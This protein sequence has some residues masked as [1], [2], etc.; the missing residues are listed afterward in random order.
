MDKNW[1]FLT[2]DIVCV[3]RLRH[4]LGCEEAI[5]RSLVN[6]GIHDP[7]HAQA[8]IHTSLN[9]LKP[10]FCLKDMDKAVERTARA[11]H[12]NESIL[13]FG[14][15]DADGITATTILCGFLRECGAHVSS[16]LPHR[17]NEGY[18]LKPRHIVHFKDNMRPD[19]LITV[20]CGTSSHDAVKEATAAGIDV[21]I[22]DHHDAESSPPPA[23]AV[24]NPKQPGCTSGL[25]H[26][27]GVGVAFYFIMALRKYLRDHH[28]FKNR[29]EPNLKQMCDLVAIGT[30]A[31]MVPLVDENR[32]FIHTGVHVLKTAT[33]HGLK[34]LMHMAQ[35]TQ[36][37]LTAEDIAFKIA[38]RINSAGRI[39]HAQIA[40]D[41]LN[42]SN[43]GRCL[44]LAQHLE[45]LNTRRKEMETGILDQIETY[46]Q[47][48]GTGHQRSIVLASNYWHLGVLGIVCSRLVN[49]YFKPA[50]LI[51][52]QND[53][54]TG[55]GRSIPGIDL[56]Q[57][58]S[59]C[60]EDLLQFGGHQMAIG[61]SIASENVQ[62]FRDRFE[63]LLSDTTT[64]DDF[65]P[66]LDIDAVLDFDDINDTLIDQL[67]SLQPFGESHPEPVF[68]T[69]NIHIDHEKK[70]GDRHKRFV[71]RQKHGRSDKKFNAVFFNAPPSDD[72]DHIA[73][74]IKWNR[75]NGQKTPQLVLTDIKK[76]PCN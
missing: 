9:R 53:K 7:K 13:V 26:L 18:G 22:T 52:L 54:G 12:E 17:I 21:I 70:I 60:K 11:I 55:S 23:Y 42:D 43:E 58:V 33:R 40:Y 49:K 5:A 34:A 10:P 4:T 16:Y 66:S 41:L 74:S 62:S 25:A 67:E 30:L 31:D 76:T 44:K 63:K 36:E 35:I 69:R 29:P 75:W 1:H 6:R 3:K 37:K 65:I 47:K 45:T 15:Y 27:A 50:I 59:R 71:L 14:D 46:L 56:F 73:Y 19:L 48:K 8:H 20:D 38:P 51:S 64:S 57:G 24:L 61:L 39:D 72:F 32:I 28:F 2:P 68:V